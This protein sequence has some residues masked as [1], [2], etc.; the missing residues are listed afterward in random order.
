MLFYTVHDHT[1]ATGS[2]YA[3]LVRPC[4]DR[5]TATR[6]TSPREFPASSIEDRGNRGGP[7][8]DELLGL[9]AS[10][11]PSL[12]FS[13]SHGLGPP[14][15][16]SWSEE[17]AREFQGAMSFGADG[18]IV[19]A[20]I[21]ARRFLPGGLWFYLACF[22]AGTPV[23]SAYH[24]WLAMLRAQG[25]HGLDSLQAVQGALARQEGFTSGLAQAALA[26]PDGPLAM[27]GHIDLAWSHGYEELRCDEDGRLS[28]I[29]RATHYVNLLAKLIRG[30]RIGAAFLHL[31][32]EIDRVGRELNAR[33]DRCKQRG[34][35]PEGA[36]RAERLT[37]GNLWML[38]QD[39]LGYVILGDPAVRLPLAGKH[40]PAIQELRA[41]FLAQGDREP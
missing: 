14:R 1:A 40:K 7:D 33:Y 25:M 17:H 37:I 2:G 13:V 15:R 18:P 27:L 4:F 38:Q 32:Q 6:R 3:K 30:D 21:A 34:V 23:T 28:G 29:D 16:E 20:D 8:R 22:G 35:H 31:Q 24:H 9:V 10:C 41:R 11:H 5:C 19:P 12:L 36:S 26:N 39:L